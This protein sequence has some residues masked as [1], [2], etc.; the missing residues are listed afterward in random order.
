MLGRDQI[1][2]EVKEF[3][4]TLQ[5]LLPEVRRDIMELFAPTTYKAIEASNRKSFSIDGKALSIIWKLIFFS[6]VF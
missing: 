1:I 4:D 2:P 5:T 3:R 6:L